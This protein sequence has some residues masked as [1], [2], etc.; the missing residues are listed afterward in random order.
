MKQGRAMAA[1]L[2]QDALAEA[3]DRKIEAVTRGALEV[4]WDESQGFFVSGQERQISWASQVWFILAEVLSREENVRLLERLEKINP[5]LGMVTPYM[6]HHYVEALLHC[7]RKEQAIRC[8]KEYWGEMIRDGGDTFFEVYDPR[9]K[10]S[11][12]YGGRII[13]SFCHAWSGTPAYFIRKFLS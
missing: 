13:N 6:Y 2:G 3:Y 11:S 5:P 10:E 8:L 9:N 7:G 4:L 12:P 1:W